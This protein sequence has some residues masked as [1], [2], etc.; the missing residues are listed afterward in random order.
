[1]PYATLPSERS[2]CN[3]QKESPQVESHTRSLVIKL[4]EDADG[5]PSGDRLGEPHS[6]LGNPA[7]RQVLGI[8]LRLR[9]RSCERNVGDS[10]ELGRMGIP[11]PTHQRSG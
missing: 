11:D 2:D 4:P 5:N 1:M 3:R 9:S 8:K 10:W 6:R 7:L